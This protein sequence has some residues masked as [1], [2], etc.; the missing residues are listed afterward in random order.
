M[1]NR[2][3]TDIIERTSYL[4]NL[5]DDQAAVL[6]AAANNLKTAQDA[7]A[8]VRPLL[9]VRSFR[10]LLWGPPG[11]GKTYALRRLGETLVERGS[12][13]L[14]YLDADRDAAFSKGLDPQE[15]QVAPLLHAASGNEALEHIR[16]QVKNLINLIGKGVQSARD[17]KHAGYALDTI[18]SW[19]DVAWGAKSTMDLDLT[20][21]K[22]GAGDGT[23]MHANK[24]MAMVSMIIKNASIAIF[25]ATDGNL[26]KDT[27]QVSGPFVTAMVA[28]AK[29]IKADVKGGFGPHERWILDLGGR[30]AEAVF[31]KADFSLGFGLDKAPDKPASSYHF[32][33]DKT[34]YAHVKARLPNA[35]AVALAEKSAKTADVAG[36]VTGLY[37]MRV[38]DAIAHIAEQNPS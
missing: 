1:A 37:E 6:H 35:D 32:D 23:Q 11:S 30:T 26:L 8:L 2:L 20:V 31:G 33:F 18:T 9:S 29:S 38:R 7:Q 24:I 25:T 12:K 15:V 36:L 5:D 21:G 13:P 17:G 4:C 16:N 27:P 3:V 19:A 28:H 10:L 22:G 34:K 14:F